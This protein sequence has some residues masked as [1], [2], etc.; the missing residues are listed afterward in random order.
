MA[1]TLNSYLSRPSTK[2]AFVLYKRYVHIAG[3]IYGE[4]DVQMEK[5]SYTMPGTKYQPVPYEG[6]FTEKEKELLNKKGLEYAHLVAES[7]YFLDALCKPVKFKGEENLTDNMV[8]ITYRYGRRILR[9]KWEILDFINENSEFAIT[10][11]RTPK[12]LI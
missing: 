3:K 1:T 4:G 10:V 12:G 9:G 6:V 7:G 2:P 5:Y 11:Y 8:A